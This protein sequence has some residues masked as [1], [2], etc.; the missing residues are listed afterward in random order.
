MEI[1]LNFDINQKWIFDGKKKWNING[2]QKGVFDGNQ[3]GDMWT[4]KA[5]GVLIEKNRC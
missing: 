4:W 1:G 3:V 5:D 2:H